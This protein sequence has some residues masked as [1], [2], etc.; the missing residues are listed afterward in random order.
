M[1]REHIRAFADVPSVRLRGIQSRSRDRAEALA[2]EYGIP[3]V[4]DSVQELY[5]R[6]GAHLLV[7]SV[8]E[9]AANQV[10]RAAFAFPWTI[11]LEK[12]AGYDLADA[13]D[14]DE[15]AG[16]RRQDVYVALNRRF[17]SSTRKALANLA[18]VDG[19][20][21]VKVMDQQD[22]AAAVMAGQPKVVVDN[23]MFANSIHTIDYLS[24]FGRGNVINV[25]S[26]VPW[27][28]K[29]SGVVVAKI[30]FD[31]GDLGLYEG[32]WNGPGPWAV[33]VS[34]PSVRW[35]MR[36]LE[37]LAFQPAGERRLHQVEPDVWDTEF[38]PG[39]RWQAQEAVAAARGQPTTLPSMSDALGT[40]RLVDR[41]FS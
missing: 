36:P 22:Q 1:S 40:M 27:T 2:A 3:E 29:T 7:V 4:C 21:F 10:A 24:L 6:T 9:L 11:L 13:M 30:E 23:W 33:Q 31:S 38:K 39:L 17:F 16:A 15:A 5:E 35:E 34:T 26:V 12:P 19:P 18:E 25:E 32:I 20:R 14:I 8:P 37:Q 41:I 28:P